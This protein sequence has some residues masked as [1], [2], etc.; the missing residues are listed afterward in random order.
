MSSTVSSKPLP[1]SISE[2]R[3]SGG[4]P[5]N[6]LTKEHAVC[7]LQAVQASP[8]HYQVSTSPL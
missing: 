7:G 1:D 6:P 5:P 4:M 8:T 2:V 3:I